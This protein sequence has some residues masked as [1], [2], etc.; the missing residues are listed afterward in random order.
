MSTPART[1]IVVGVDGS[2]ESTAALSFAH[3]EAKLRGLPL[4]IV[5]A[6]EP[7]TASYAG[8]AFAATPDAFLEAE[9][10]ADDVLRAALEHLPEDGVQVEAVA[11]EGRPASVL[12]DQAVGA[13]LVVV[14]SRGRGATKR[15]LLGSVGHDLA[16]HVRC[17]LVIVPSHG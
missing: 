11:I 5:C 9:H 17:P 13:E 14:G 1:R 2:P 7:A 15:L 10:H 8:E 3:T 16:H 6:W 4:R 12:L